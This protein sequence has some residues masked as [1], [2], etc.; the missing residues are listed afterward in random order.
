MSAN[1]NQPILASLLSIDQ[2]TACNMAEIFFILFDYCEV[3]YKDE[4]D[5]TENAT[6]QSIRGS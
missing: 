3:Y 2:L 1:V 5:E 6:D 4:T